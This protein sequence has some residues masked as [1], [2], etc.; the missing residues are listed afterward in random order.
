MK[1]ALILVQ[2][3][4]AKRHYI[5]K[6]L[7][8]YLLLHKQRANENY[9]RPQIWNLKKPYAKYMVGSTLT[10]YDVII[11]IDTEK[12]LWGWSLFGLFD[13]VGD[14]LFGNLGR[15]NKV[16][17]AV[18]Q[19]QD[20]LFEKYNITASN[21]DALVHSYGGQILAGSG[22][23][24]GNVVFAG[25]PISSSIDYIR[26]RTYLE[27][28]SKQGMIC[29]NLY[30]LW[31]PFD[32]VCSYPPQKSYLKELGIVAKNNL[33]RVQ[34]SKGHDFF[35]SQNLNESYL[36]HADFMLQIRGQSACYASKRYRDSK[37]TD[38]CLMR[39]DT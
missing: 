37:S 3:V 17:K 15:A 10:K 33:S 32:K 9:V 13:K 12:Y 11:S 24:F 1:K 6:D 19:A 30:Y 5:F 2:G 21:T 35:R 31:N 29:D 8:Q 14:W 20:W 34:V 38:Y 36:I 23:S 25:V 4:S 26:G 7:I 22:C 39:N 28:I 18:K 27:L 16:R